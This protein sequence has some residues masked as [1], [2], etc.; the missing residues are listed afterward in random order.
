MAQN[1]TVRDLQGA[2]LSGRTDRV[3]ND[4]LTEGWLTSGASDANA[5]KVLPQGTPNMTVRAGSG[6]AGDVYVVVSTAARGTYLV[7]NPDP[8]IGSGNSDIPIAN[9]DASNPR[10]DGIDLKVWDNTEDSSGFNKSEI[11]VTQGTPASSPAAPAIPAG[12]VRLATVAV[13]T[14]LST[15]IVS[16]NITD[17]RKVS[18][19]KNSPFVIVANATARDALLAREGIHAYTEDTNTLWF[20]NGTAWRF[21][22]GPPPRFRVIGGGAG[23]TGIAHNVATTFTWANGTEVIDTEGAIAIGTGVFTCPSAFAGRWRFDFATLWEPD[24]DGFRLVWLEH[25][26][27]NTRY[28]EAIMNTTPAGIGANQAG[29]SDIVLAAGETVVV[30]GQHFSG[31]NRTANTSTNQYFQGHYVGPA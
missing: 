15:S 12:C 21:Q 28:S 23:Q 24:P 2:L 22:A 11:I 30:R 1:M 31:E 14:G 5:F 4:V 7:R 18:Q 19:T 20:Y 27:G 9:G 25:S 26:V 13:A 10:I 29:S 17:T 8:Y 6:T 16:G 3:I